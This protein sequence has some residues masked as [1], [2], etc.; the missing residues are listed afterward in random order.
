MEKGRPVLFK[1]GGFFFLMMFKGKHTGEF[2]L[3]APRLL[4]VLS[5]K[6]CGILNIPVEIFKHLDILAI[7][8]I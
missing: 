7:L 2:K 3:L 8:E 4:S 5:E 1:M 6:K